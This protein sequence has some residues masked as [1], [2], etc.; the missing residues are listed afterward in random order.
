MMTACASWS[1]ILTRKFRWKSNC[2]VILLRFWEP[3][4]LLKRFWSNSQFLTTPYLM[5]LYSP[6]IF[7]RFFHFNISINY[8]F[9]WTWRFKW[10]IINK[11]RIFWFFP[12]PTWLSPIK[13]CESCKLIVSI[14]NCKFCLIW[15]FG[16]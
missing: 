16:W 14:N 5:Y 7:T 1:R 8:Q 12:N 10:F 3:K 11:F 13:S 2:F 9:T 15:Q 4:S 6:P